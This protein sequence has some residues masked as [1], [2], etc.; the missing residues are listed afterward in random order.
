[1]ANGCSLFGGIVPNVYIDQVFLEEARE[2]TDNDGKV[3][4]ETPVIT[5]N[6]K[7]KIENI[8]K[9]NMVYNHKNKIK[10]GICPQ[11][12]THLKKMI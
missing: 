10:N 11:D 8:I 4:L 12:I 2:D 1:M 9:S 3:D 6:V 7:L 5:V